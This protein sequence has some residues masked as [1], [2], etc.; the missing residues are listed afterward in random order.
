M[1]PVS[2]EKKKTLVEIIVLQNPSSKWHRGWPSCRPN[3]SLVY[4]H[5]QSTSLYM[6]MSLCRD[7]IIFGI[8]RDNNAKVNHRVTKRAKNHAFWNHYVIEQ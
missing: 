8:C 5:M 3:T 2:G 7:N 4:M 1:R 6:I